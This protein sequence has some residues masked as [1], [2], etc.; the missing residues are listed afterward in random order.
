MLSTVSDGRR[1]AGVPVGTV[2]D[3]G[4]SGDSFEP[5]TSWDSGDDGDSGDSGNMVEIVLDIAG[6]LC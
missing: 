3:G 2:E 4:H 5:W 6:G 1:C